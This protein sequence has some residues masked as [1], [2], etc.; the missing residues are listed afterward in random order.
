[1]KQRAT[2]NA[3]R[4]G[5]SVLLVFACARAP[6]PPPAVEPPAP[7]IASPPPCPQIV[8][9]EVRKRDRRLR[10]RCDGGEVV[11]MPVALGRASTGPKRGVGDER[12]PEGYYRISGPPRPSRFHVFVPIDYPSLA[13][14]ATAYA[15]GRLSDTEY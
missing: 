2:C 10:A 15:E 4:W 14:A 3:L 8:L 7:A 11:E 5:A 9:I 1:M 13:D 6:G 12:T